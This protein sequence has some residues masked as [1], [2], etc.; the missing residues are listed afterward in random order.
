MDDDSQFHSNVLYQNTFLLFDPGSILERDNGHRLKSLSLGLYSS[1]S[2]VEG[3]T[4]FLSSCSVNLTGLLL[5]LCLFSPL[6][7]LLCS[8]AGAVV[9]AAAVVT[10][11]TAGAASAAAPAPA[12]AAA[13]APT[14]T[15]APA[16]APAVASAAAVATV[17]AATAAAG[18][19]RAAVIAG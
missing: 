19:R 11:V 13:P 18:T 12:L 10:V 8:E 17:A 7:Y 16:V 2:A 4:S 9:A 5:C 6:C 1:A 15:A 14:A 3:D